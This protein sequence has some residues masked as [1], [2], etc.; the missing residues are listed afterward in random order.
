L[1]SVYTREIKLLIRISNAGYIASLAR[2][3]NTVNGKERIINCLYDDESIDKEIA[4]EVADIIIQAIIYAKEI[5]KSYNEELQKQAALKE[6]QDK[7]TVIIKMRD[8]L[9][10]SF[11]KII[12]SYGIEVLDNYN[13]CRA[14]LKDMA[15]GNYV[16]EITLISSLLEKRI[17][18]DILKPR[19]FKIRND[20]L[21]LKL[22][23][24]YADTHNFG[25]DTKTIIELIIAVVDKAIGQ[26]KTE[27]G[28]KSW[29]TN[30]FKS[31]KE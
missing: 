5:E 30:L 23:E 11:S 1:N 15:Q 13:F 20:A 4:F 8:I 17:Q 24:R 3:D 26:S 7:A 14:I 12:K 2:L 31:S 19:L 28:I 18:K 9:E 10:T 16:D 29:T 27:G 6:S 21:I 25:V 22:S